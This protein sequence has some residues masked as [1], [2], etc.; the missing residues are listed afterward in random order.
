MSYNLKKLKRANLYKVLVCNS[1]NIAKVPYGFGC[2]ICV[3][4]GDCNYECGNKY[5]CKWIDLHNFSPI[6]KKFMV[7]DFGDIVEYLGEKYVCSKDRIDFCGMCDI[8][9]ICESEGFVFCSH[10][11]EQGRE[12]RLKNRLCSFKKIEEGIKIEK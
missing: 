5:H 11:L 10:K 4:V 9:E 6:A 1:S 3:F 12:I 8:E 2:N 7:A